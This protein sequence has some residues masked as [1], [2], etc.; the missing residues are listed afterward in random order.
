MM[1][2]L[3]PVSVKVGMSFAVRSSASIGK[4][5]VMPLWLN[6]VNQFAARQISSILL[7]ALLAWTSQLKVEFFPA[8]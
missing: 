4:K 8:R 1:F 2:W 3:V 5:R 7:C 6:G